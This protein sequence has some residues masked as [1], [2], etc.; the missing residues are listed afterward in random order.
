M[1]MPEVF[2]YGNY[3][4]NIKLTSMET[5]KDVVWVRGNSFVLVDDPKRGD[6]LLNGQRVALLSIN[7]MGEIRWPV[8]HRDIIDAMHY[9]AEGK[10]ANTWDC[11]MHYEAFRHFG[12]AIYA[13]E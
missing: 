7:G 12:L 2:D 3:G 8:W 9:L 10:G 1:A 4:V 5:N 6:F 13:G 11:F